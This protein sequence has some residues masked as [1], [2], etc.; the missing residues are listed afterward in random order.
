MKRNG[1]LLLI[2]TA[3]VLI[4]MPLMAQ[5]QQS[6][7]EDFTTTTYEDMV[8]TTADW[9]TADGELK[10]FPFELSLAGTYDTPSSSNDVV[11]AGDHAFVADG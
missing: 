4:G 8:G 6:H 1:N 10:L 7:T 11:V 3:T 9:N 5:A 2:L